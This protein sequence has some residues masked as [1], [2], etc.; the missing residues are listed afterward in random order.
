VRWI[1]IPEPDPGPGAAEQ[2]RVYDQGRAAGG[3][4][5]RRLEGAVWG[6]GSVY[7]SATTGG[8]AELGQIWRYT[9]PSVSFA[10][11]RRQRAVIRGGVRRAEDG[12]L[13]LLFE[14]RDPA[15]LKAPDNVCLAPRGSLLICEDSS[16]GAQYVRVLTPSGQ[17]FDLVRN[18]YPGL[19]HSELAGVTFSP[20]G[21]T[22]FLNIYGVAMTVAI[23][24]PWGSGTL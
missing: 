2:R 10:Q 1:D 13:T 16:V 9:P 14:S 22:L 7:F 20:D 5:F 15:L 6:N 19:E 3:A 23:W 4:R 17:L 21:E 18:S 11:P 24:G 12:E 8:D